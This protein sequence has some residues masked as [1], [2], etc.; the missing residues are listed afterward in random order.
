ML[1][2]ESFLEFPDFL[3]HDRGSSRTLCHSWQGITPFPVTMY[4]QSAYVKEL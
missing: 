1:G 4:T 2:I 3:Q